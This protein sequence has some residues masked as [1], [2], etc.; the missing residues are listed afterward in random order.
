[1]EDAHNRFTQKG[2]YRKDFDLV[3]LFFRRQGNRIGNDQFG[4]DRFL[5]SFDSRIGED[6]MSAGRKD[7][8]S[9]HFFQGFGAAA[10]GTCR[11]DDIVDEDAGLAFDIAND[12]HDFSNA[13]AGTAFFDDGNGRTDPVSQVTSTGYTAEVRRYDDEVSQ[14]GFFFFWLIYRAMMEAEPR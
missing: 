11:I 10:Q 6:G 2:S 13:R 4:D 9:S 12:I 1:M 14:I 7:A 5:N 8:G 3:A